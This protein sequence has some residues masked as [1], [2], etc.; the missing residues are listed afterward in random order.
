METNFEIVENYAVWLGGIHIDLHNNFDY[1]GLS[2]NEGNISIEFIQTTGDWVTKE[3]MKSLIFHFVNVSYEYY[4]DGAPEALKEDT[5]RLGEI[6]F[7]PNYSREINDG[8]IHQ[9]KPKETDDL[10]LF[11]EDGKVIRI[12]CEKIKLAVKK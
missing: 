11:F 4:E 12:G 5:E 1:V 6:T 2:K 9:N 10:M 8:Y 7:F 3:E